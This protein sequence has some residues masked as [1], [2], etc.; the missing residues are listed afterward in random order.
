MEQVIAGRALF[1]VASSIL[2]LLNLVTFVAAYPQ[3]ANVEGQPKVLETSL[4]LLSLYAGRK[5]RPVT[6]GLLVGLSFFDPRFGLVAIPLFLTWNLEKLRAAFVSFVLTLLISNIPLFFNGTGFGYVG[7]VMS[8]GITSILYP[9]A[10]VPL[11]TVAALT[12]LYRR[13]VAAALR[14][15]WMRYVSDKV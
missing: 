15:S 11:L 13:E 12:W 6:S 3:A 2:I 10:L 8:T 7:M 1:F 4:L 5:N 9:Y 14:L